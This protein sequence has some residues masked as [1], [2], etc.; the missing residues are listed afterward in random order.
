MAN[1]PSDNDN[2]FVV[3]NLNNNI[4]ALKNKLSSV[5]TPQTY[6]NIRYT[7][8]NISEQETELENIL[9]NGHMVNYE[10]FKKGVVPIAGKLV[11]PGEAKKLTTT[12]SIPITKQVVQTSTSATPAT[13]TTT[14]A[15]ATVTAPAPATT[16]ATTPATAT[17]TTPATT[18]ATTSAKKKSKKKKFK[19]KK[20]KKEK[21]VIDGGS[22][23]KSTKKKRS[24]KM[25]R[26]GRNKWTKRSG[27]AKRSNRKSY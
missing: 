4:I 5:G 15:T 26:T 20:S 1:N 12:P 25:I 21:S 7:L 6:N 23:K 16:S 19:K 13:P 22:K 10:G 18:T 11:T 17:A 27:S 14:P 3:K 9:D 24:T 8:Y 2:I